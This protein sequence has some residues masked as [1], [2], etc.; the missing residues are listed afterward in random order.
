MP[1][2][3]YKR[4][5]KLFRN[6]SN[7]GVYLRN[8]MRRSGTTLSF[9]TRPHPIKIGVPAN[10]FLVFKEIFMS[11]VYDID[12]LLKHLPE[13]PTVVDIGANAGYFDLILLSKIDKARIYAYE[14][15][16]ANVALFRDTIERNN[17]G[18]HIA[19]LPMAVTGVQQGHLD[20][21]VED[22]RNNTVMASVF[23]GFNDSNTQKISVPCISLT[24]I[25]EENNLISIDVLK[26]DCEG[27]EFDIIY[28]TPAEL[29]KRATLIAVE[30][31]D[32]DKNKNNI[33]YFDRYLQSMGYETT[34]TQINGFCHAVTAIK[35]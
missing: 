10:L 16:P 23:A 33:A 19:L 24:H 30:V 29:I 12:E 17:L 26:I 14:P 4:Y 11:D 15:M 35:K 3:G 32:M 6:I 18:E 34:H 8:K 20:L 22:E 1:I 9:V 27:S 21:F 13:N 25:I 2:Q 7:P 28:N 5:F 31:H